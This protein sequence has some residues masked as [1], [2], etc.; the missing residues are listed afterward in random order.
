MVGGRYQSGNHQPYNQDRMRTFREIAANGA[1]AIQVLLIFLLAV[2]NQVQLPAWLQVAGRLH[3]MVLHLPIGFLVLA[4]VLPLAQQ[5]LPNFAYRQVQDLLIH[6]AAL[7]AAVTA[8]FGFFLSREDG[9][10]PEL[11]NWHK[12][13]GVGVSFMSYALLLLVRR[14][15]GRPGG[16]NAGL[17]ATALVLVVAGH[18]GSE[19]THGEGYVLAPV[20]KHKPVVTEET[21]LF[22]AAVVPVLDKYCFSCHN[23]RKSKGELVMTTAEG[24]RQ[25][26]ENGDLW[27]AGDPEGSL[28]LQRLLLPPDHDDHMPPEGKQQPSAAEIRLIEAWIRA[29]ADEGLPLRAYA[30]DGEARLLAAQV[31]AAT[32]GK[33]E[34]AESYDFKEAPA[35]VVKKLNTPFRTVMPLA[36]GSPALAAAIFVRETYQ[37]QFLKELEAVKEQLVELNLSNLPIGDDDLAI[38]AGFDNLEKLI[39]NGTDI[40]GATLGELARCGKLTTLSLSMTTVDAGIGTALAGLP[41]LREVYIWQTAID[42]AAAAELTRQL[43]QVTFYQGFIP[44]PEEYLP[45]SPPLLENKNPLLAGD[46]RVVLRH[47]LPG[48]EI[49]YTLDGS[50]PDSSASPVYQ[51]PLQLEGYTVLK[52]K[53]FRDHWKSSETLTSFFFPKGLAPQEG[54]LINYPNPQYKGDGFA[55]LT[56]GGKGDA[57]NFRS[58]FWLGYQDQPFAAIFDFGSSS[59]PINHVTLSYAQNMGAYIMPPVSVEVW[60]GH[61]EGQLRLLNRLQPA[62]PSGYGPNQVCGLEIPIES[63][64]YRFVKVVA[65]PVK[66]LPA[67]HAGKGD[68]GWVF[69]DEVF[70]Y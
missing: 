47:N 42:P 69:V 28:L 55:S 16:F 3:P 34:T 7:T 2:E 38:I 50:E 61:E 11:L 51:E 57:G 62:P 27:R 67:W 9:Y 18:L 66:K 24:R 32:S 48:A 40:T 49:R 10:S 46:D 60:G 19:L 63:G 26:G 31:L 68:K 54:K 64:A 43:P 23:E 5:E 41:A 39:L 33:V 4:A 36:N 37:P 35:A 53:A 13:T 59:A 44:D 20:R 21:P 45:L 12:W 15:F 8:I 70:F 17:A 65:E 6:F 25:G 29:G 1:F 30:G 52:A 56:D 14:G 58:A 22:E